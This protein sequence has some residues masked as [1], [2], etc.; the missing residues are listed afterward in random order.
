MA[1]TIRTAAVIGSGIMGSGIAA[2]LANVGVNC[3]LLDI[4]PGKLTEKEEAAGLT[5]NDGKVRNRLAV[6]ALEK[7]KSTQPSPLYLDSFMERITPGNL[8]DHL[9]RLRDVDWIIEV[10]VENLPVKQELLQKIESVWTPGTIV[11][12]NTSG[13]SINAMVEQCGEAFKKHFLGTHF[14]NPPRYMQLLEVI[15]GRMT[16]PE[17]VSFMS[18]FC[19]KRLGKGVVMAKDTPNFIGNRIGIYGLLVTLQEMR[20]KGC[21]VEEVDAVTGPVMGRPRSATFRTLDLVGIDTFVH[22]AQNVQDNVDQAEE[23]AVFQVPE[24]IREMVAR[25]WNGDKSGQGFYKKVKAAG[26]NTI[27]SLDPNTMEYTPR[28]KISSASL[29]A[30]KLAKGAAE[31]TKTLIYGGDRYSELAWSILKKVL[32]YSADKLGEIADNIVDIDNA[33]KWG[34]NWELGPFETW[35]AIG[36]VKSV[37]RMEAEGV[38]VPQWVKDWIAAGNVN[39]YKR[40]K[41]HAFYCLKGEYHRAEVEPEMI[42]LKGLKDQGRVVKSNSGGNLI[43]LGDGVVCLEFQSPNNAI[44][45]DILNMIRLSMDEVDKNYKGLIIANEGRNFSVGANLM[46]I[47]MQAQDEEWDEVELMIHQF[48]QTLLQLKHFTKPVVVAPH[49]MTLGGGVEICLAGDQV[50]ASAETYMGLVEVGVGVIPGGGGCKELALRLSRKIT[51]PEVDLQP[52]MNQLFETIGMAKVSSSGHESIRLGYMRET[53]KV[54]VNRDY[55][56]HEAKQAVLRM[57]NEGYVPQSNEKFRVVGENGKAVMQLGAYSLRQSAFISDYDLHVANKLAHVLAGGDVPA[58]TLVTE[59]YML[60]L[61]K[62][63]FLS[64]CGEPKTQQRM[65]HMLTK[66]KPLRN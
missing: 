26:E 4:V 43:D 32:V 56:I 49:R 1:R 66:G 62:E 48:Q 54:V 35:D 6:S 39:F 46:L 2:H 25:G 12:T 47:L 18:D 7:M 22:V 14:F 57:D 31:K 8:E 51:D 10:I 19:R 16:D 42:S 58:G 36:L 65:Q 63:A 55:Q 41:G 29:E 17:I 24:M 23:K 53:D 28:A 20:E 33:M 13:I 45:A 52:F 60:D 40:E 37:Q 3:L 27:L 15:P 50:Y 59:Q 21:S 64:L 30:A 11:S 44:G 38:A 61:E 5:L 34:F 9:D